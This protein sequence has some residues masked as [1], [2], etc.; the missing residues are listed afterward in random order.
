MFQD[1]SAGARERYWSK[2]GWY[3]LVAVFVHRDYP[4]HIPFHWDPIEG[5]RLA[6]HEGDVVTN[7]FFTPSWKYFVNIIGRTSF[8]SISVRKQS[9]NSL[10]CDD[11]LVHF[12]GARWHN[13]NSWV[14][15]V[16]CGEHTLLKWP[17]HKEAWKQISSE[18]R[19]EV[20]DP[21]GLTWI[22]NVCRVV[23][24]KFDPSLVLVPSIEKTYLEAENGDSLHSLFTP[25]IRRLRWMMSLIIEW[26][27]IFMFLY[28][29]GI[30]TDML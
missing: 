29:V 24:I 6:K 15:D 21:L 17:F 19:Q 30:N 4:A 13:V 20:W 28:S 23:F 3:R 12:F 5:W 22:Q 16:V 11:E 2:V 7:P 9:K 25:G 1:F 10:F 8:F 14:T 18:E 27:C 26:F